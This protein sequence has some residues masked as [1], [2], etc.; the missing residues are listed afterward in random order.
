MIGFALSHVAVFEERVAPLPGGELDAPAGSAES[1]PAAPAAQVAPSDPGDLVPRARPRFS[2]PSWEVPGGWVVYDIGRDSLDA[3]CCQ[4]GH[5][6]PTNAC[7]LNRSAMPD[8]RGRLTAQGRPIGLLLAWLAAGS[9]RPTRDTHHGM[10]IARRRTA[11]DSDV[12]SY[13]RRLALR[14]WAQLQPGLQDML[15]KERARRPEESDEPEG[16][17]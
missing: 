11:V 4:A 16:L 13:V 2:N 12:L 7:R 15:Q 8:A 5:H 17:A 14:Q 1:A 9:E 10:S 3:H 6:V